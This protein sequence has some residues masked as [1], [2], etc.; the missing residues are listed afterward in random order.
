MNSYKQYLNIFLVAVLVV[1]VAN[2]DLFEGQDLRLDED[3]LEVEFFPQTENIGL[4]QDSLGN[5]LPTG[6]VIVDI[7]L[8]GRQMDEDLS[9]EFVVDNANTSAVAGQ[10][11]N[12]TT[13]S[14]AVIPANSSEDKITID[15]VDD[16]L[17]PGDDPVVL[18]LELQDPGNGVVAAPNLK[19]HTLTIF[20][21]E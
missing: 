16:G 12:I 15:I 18:T 11:Y 7:Q 21:P 10:H 20:P 19:T 3:R 5:P 14:P 4:A 6:P 8:I 17:Q 9:V 2:C 1:T 13:P